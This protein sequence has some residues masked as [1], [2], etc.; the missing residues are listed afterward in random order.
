LK[1]K[2]SERWIPNAGDDSVNAP[3]G[4]IELE[5]SLVG[6]FSDD[7]TESALREGAP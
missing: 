5:T 1:G 7:M 3:D 2:V 6:A 4:Y